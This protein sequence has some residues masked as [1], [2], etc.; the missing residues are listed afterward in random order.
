MY[1]APA[2]ILGKPGPC[3]PPRAEVRSR[4]VVTTGTPSAP[5]FPTTDEDWARRPYF[6]WDY[7]VSWTEL[8]AMLAGDSASRRRWALSRVL[9]LARW[10]HIWRL[11]TIDDIA[12]D[13]DALA[14]RDGAFWRA[15]VA[16]RRPPR[17][18]DNA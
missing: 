1:K 13:V 12:D 16:A 2:G 10:E 4:N 6:I 7:P 14:I 15:L 18:R 17:R 9:D 8:V 5:P 11:V 3:G